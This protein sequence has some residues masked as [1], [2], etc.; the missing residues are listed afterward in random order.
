MAISRRSFMKDMGILAGLSSGA[1]KLLGGSAP[2]LNSGQA[3]SAGTAPGPIPRIVVKNFSEKFYSAYL[4]NGLIGIRPGPN[5]LVPAKTMV[6]GFVYANIQYKV[7]SL[8]PAPYPLATDFRVND[9]SLLKHPE[10]VKVEQ[11]TLDMASGELLTQI[12]FMPPNGVTLR[13]NVLQFA[14]RAVPSLLCQMS[15]FSVSSDAKVEVHACIDAAE[16][17]G[18]IYSTRP[19]ES[20]EIDLA[21]GYLSQGGLSK[22]GVAVTVPVGEDFKNRGVQVTGRASFAAGFSLDAKAGQ[23][24]RFPTIAAMV[25]DF[26]QPEP[27]QEAIRQA[28]WGAMLGFDRLRR[29]NREHWSSL[30]QS[31]VKVYRDSGSQ[32]VL[33]SAFFYLHS[34]LHPSNKNGMAPFGLSQFD[35]YCG[36]S[37]WDTETWSLLPITL[38]APA[39]AKSLLE[40]RLRGLENARRL[41]ALYG[42]RGAQFPWEAS[43]IDG[44]DVTPAFAGTGW[45]EQHITPDV[46]LGFWEYQMATADEEFL[47]DG[48]WPVLRAVAEWIESRSVRTSRGF[49]IQ[50]IMGPDEGVENVN[51]NSYMNV[52]CRMVMEAA[53]RCAGLVGAKPP[54]AWAAIARSIV[55]P[56]DKARNIVL[57][58]DHPPQGPNYSLGNMAMLTVHDPPLVQ[59]LLKNTYEYE[60]KLRA[61]RP[62]GIGF[63]LDAVA[64]TA[65][66]FGDRSAAA[67]LY[68]KSWQNVWV[69]P[70]GMIKEAP[71][72]DYACFITNFGSLLQTAMVGFTGIRATAPGWAK[73]P[74]TLP[75]GWDS[76]EIDRVWLG[77]IP[78]SLAARNG[79]KAELSAL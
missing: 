70:Y 1:P 61:E 5:P 77:G 31:R 45:E 50:N 33:D 60:A 47:R 16:F 67:T 3:S 11:Q 79:Q 42:Y 57:P 55:I 30:W 6:N 46:A 37:F 59:S 62:Q 43:P 32:R 34:S 2:M 18:S 73:Y 68:R 44:A 12:V 27:E 14:C 66:F 25:S 21:A 15:T 36:H 76:I 19:P 28:K 17:T 78:R 20:T 9:V 58:Y 56:I 74:A 71:S 39:T 10:L 65:A 75:E 52:I 24:Y 38:A 7:V 26:Y 35:Y 8:S 29:Q 69:E 41:A 13:L 72:E 54:A 23:V 53:V 48:T 22:L 63:A 64:A 51:N 49:E 4:S 40:F